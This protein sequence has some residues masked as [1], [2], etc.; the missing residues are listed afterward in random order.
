MRNFELRV[1]TL[2][3]REAS[4]QYMSAIYPRHLNSFPLFGIEPHGFWTAAEDIGS[5]FFV[6][7]SCPEHEEPCEVVRRYVQSKEFAEDI[8]GFDARRSP[9]PQLSICAVGKPTR[10]L[11]D[12][13]CW[14][15]LV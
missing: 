4:T 7:A 6:L 3:S 12:Y 11:I 2:R 13:S 5:R 8:K 10:Y 15:S 1:Y 14:S 9:R